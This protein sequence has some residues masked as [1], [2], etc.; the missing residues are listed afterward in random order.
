MNDMF[1]RA[2][3]FATAAHAAVKQERKYTFEPYI[4]HP[5]HVVGILLVNVECTQEMLAAAW[6]HDVIEDTGVTLDLIEK[7]FGNKVAEYVNWLT[8]PSKLIDGNRAYRKEIDRQFIAN[9]PAEV[10]TIKLADLI[11]NTPSI[12][13]YD[14][15]FA[16]V[17]LPEK[18]RLLEVLTEGDARLFAICKKSLEDSLEKIT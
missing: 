5:A 9:A 2:R 4:V 14:V 1:E 13:E 7:E 16:R 3:I 12:V 6:L 17:Y 10:K 11:S 8:A 18:Q 15:G